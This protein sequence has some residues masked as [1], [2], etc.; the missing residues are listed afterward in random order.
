VH[1]RNQAG[2]LG[3]PMR[4]ICSA[5]NRTATRKFRA[6]PRRRSCNDGLS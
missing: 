3:V 2:A 5:L 6:A 1:L 4:G